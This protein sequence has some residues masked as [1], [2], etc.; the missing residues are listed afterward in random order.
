MP[1]PTPEGPEIT[2]GRR[3]LGTVGVLVEVWG[4]VGLRREMAMGNVPG[5]I[6]Y[7]RRGL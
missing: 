2:I 7:A 1:F 4:A 6:V 3:S 5:A